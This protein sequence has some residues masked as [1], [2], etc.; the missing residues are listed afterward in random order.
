MYKKYEK[1]YEKTKVL[2]LSDKIYND[3]GEHII[4]RCVKDIPCKSGI[5][6][7]GS[8]VY[9]YYANNELSIH[10]YSQYFCNEKKYVYERDDCTEINLDN[11]DEYFALDKNATKSNIYKQ[12]EIEQKHAM[13]GSFKLSVDIIIILILVVGLLFVGLSTTTTLEVTTFCILDVLLLGI[14]ALAFFIET[15]FHFIKSKQAKKKKQEYLNLSK[16]QD[17]NDFS[18]Q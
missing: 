8:L 1:K 5:F 15:I 2:T 18:F 6:T 3:K 12:I 4:F 16:C 14:I 9:M 11:F 10:T 17:K 13:E 7:K